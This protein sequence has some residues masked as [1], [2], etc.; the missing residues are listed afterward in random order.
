MRVSERKERERREEERGRE[1]R[2]KDKKG[3][4]AERKKLAE[5]NLGKRD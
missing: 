2:T 3:G 1:E 4:R 5:E